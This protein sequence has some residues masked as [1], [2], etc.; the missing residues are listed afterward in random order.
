[1]LQKEVFPKLERLCEQF[2]AK[3][4]AI[5]LRWGVRDEAQL[6]HKT[7]E[8]CLSELKRC[9]ELTPRPNFLIM[10]GNR[11]GWR[12]LPTEVNKTE[13]ENILAYYQNHNRTGFELLQEW[14]KE[15]LNRIS[16]TYCLQPRVG[17]YVE[18]NSWN[19]VEQSLRLIFDHAITELSLHK[20]D[21]GNYMISATEH[22]IKTGAFQQENAKEHV[23]AF[24]R[25][26][27]HLPSDN[28]ARDFRDFTTA[29]FVDDVSEQRVEQLKQSIRSFLPEENV[30]TYQ[31]NWQEDG[32]D[33]SYLRQFAKDVIEQLQP[34]I[35]KECQQIEQTSLVHIERDRHEQFAFERVR[36]FIGRDDLFD[37]VMRQ[38][39][40]TS[41]PLMLW[42]ASGSGKTAFA[43]ELARR[44]KL[45][46]ANAHVIQ[47]FVGASAFGTN[48]EELLESLLVELRPEEEEKIISLTE[49]DDL[50]AL[51][52]ESLKEKASEESPIYFVIDALDHLTDAHFLPQWVINEL[53]EHVHWVVTVAD[54]SEAYTVA[55]GIIAQGNQMKLGPLSEKEAR[56]LLQNWLLEQ[57]RTL[58][59][60]QYKLIIEA[61]RNCPLPLFLKL[62]FEE[63]RHWKSY[64]TNVEIQP[65]IRG[66]I[67]QFLRR[68]ADD[69]NH[70]PVLIRNVF[71]LLAASRSGLDE[72][73]LLVLLSNTEE[74]MED[75]HSRSKHD[76]ADDH[77]PP[78]I[79]ARLF[80]EL[81]PY[82]I[83][84]NESG[85][86]VYSFYHRQLETM[87]REI[88][89]RDEFNQR[90]ADY[91]YDKPTHMDRENRIPNLRKVAELPFQLYRTSDTVR[92]EEVLTNLEFLQAKFTAALSHDLLHDFSLL[93]QLAQDNKYPINKVADFDQFCRVRHQ[94]LLQYPEQLKV[95]GLQRPKD[96]YVFKEVVR[97][98]EERDLPYLIGYETEIYEDKLLHNFKLPDD[99]ASLCRIHPNGKQLIVISKDLI[100]LWDIHTGDEVF[101]YHPQLGE[102]QAIDIAYESNRIAV[103]GKKGL[104]V[105]EASSYKVL[106]DSS[107]DKEL[108]DVAIHP[109]G[110]YL[111]IDYDHGNVL[112]R[113]INQE[114]DFFIKKVRRSI[115][116]IKWHPSKRILAIW[117]ENDEI[118]VW[119][120]D[121]K[122]RLHILSS[123]FLFEHAHPSDYYDLV[124]DPI[125]PIL[126]SSNHNGLTL[127][128][129]E[130]GV[131]LNSTVGLQKGSH[132]IDQGRIYSIMLNQQVKVWDFNRSCYFSKEQ[133]FFQF[134]KDATIHNGLLAVLSLENTV[135]IWDLSTLRAVLDSDPVKMIEDSFLWVFEPILSTIASSLNVNFFRSKSSVTG[136]IVNVMERKVSGYHNVLDQKVLSV[137]V[138][139]T[140]SYVST[141]HLGSYLQVTNRRD[142]SIVQ[143]KPPNTGLITL[144][145]WSWDESLIF[146][147]TISTAWVMTT[148]G[149]L[150]K[151][152]RTKATFIEGSWSPTSKQLLVL[153]TD[154]EV[155]L[156]D[157][158]MESTHKWQLEVDDCKHM[159]ASWSNSGGYF[160]LSYEKVFLLYELSELNVEPTLIVKG[161]LTEP[162]HKIFWNESDH[163]LVLIND[164]L[165]A[166][167]FIITDGEIQSAFDIVAQ[168]ER[169]KYKDYYDRIIS[170]PSER[171]PELRAVIQQGNGK[172]ANIETIVESLPFQVLTAWNSNQRKVAFAYGH[173]VTVIFLD[174]LSKRTHWYEG[175]GIFH[176]RWEK[177]HLS[178]L[179]GDELVEK[180]IVL[181]DG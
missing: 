162:V 35:E 102:I 137:D 100:R 111:A 139:P 96:T 169:E 79:W 107:Y 42:G 126:Y 71:G 171:V 122:V 47:R 27:P 156:I 160:V 120:V 60:D 154:G 21:V 161:D 75:F 113:T 105:V 46:V 128:D 172:V 76:Y 92:F 10:L 114:E 50:V 135:T 138:S 4:Q 67:G 103:V 155:Q 6:D 112:I 1:M 34:I 158:N 54:D 134:H 23:F 57:S 173:W 82:L 142:G 149:K 88:Y 36:H 118:H 116:K 39:E 7:L 167:I 177:D 164:K 30:K 141:G 55:K 94:L 170:I 72:S 89:L 28:R 90:L 29:G 20:Q 91:Y 119:D 85:T 3:F 56:T 97:W 26:L 140:R 181:V 131:R 117:F 145:D 18:P 38:V 108:S 165:E 124:F 45:T 180:E 61:F 32:I 15:D 14:Y 31:V 84:K 48:T 168:E 33:A 152:L 49:I 5:D 125:E 129:M 81:E 68:I 136:D 63:A 24:F 157:F 77:L 144:S 148:K 166:L 150:K 13:F 65:T 19:L 51:L 146:Y 86:I 70:G 64:S 98:F 9:M 8:I 163:E 132:L 41:S 80:N 52:R 22:E 147:S 110:D 123:D 104:K 44:L 62:A 178:I 153:T 176:I 40:K 78:V 99:E 53:P 101:Q 174:D 83:E 73:E 121:E 109:S 115:Y 11:Y 69:S 175:D 127:W 133:K 74:V 93:K 130:L 143:F 66:I 179:T 17:D 16:P 106:H 43:A 12:P 151:T 95:F 2:G 58:Q 59:D 159:I 25:E 87:V 37:Q